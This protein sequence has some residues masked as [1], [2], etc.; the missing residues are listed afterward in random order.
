MADRDRDPPPDPNRWSTNKRV[1]VGDPNT[2]GART[3]R[4]GFPQDIDAE[5]HQP[6]VSQ[7]QQQ[8]IEQ[9]IAKAL[10]TANRIDPHLDQF[11]RG[12]VDARKN[13]DAPDEYQDALFQL[14]KY[15]QHDA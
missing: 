3:A 15:W 9:A 4:P 5:F 8:M 7:L 2:T 14:Q 13:M 11:Q 10:A 12:A 6:P 1:A